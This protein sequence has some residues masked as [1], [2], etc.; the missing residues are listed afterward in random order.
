MQDP[1]QLL[2]VPEALR[3]QLAHA[4]GTTLAA[5]LYAAVE[6]SPGSWCHGNL[7]GW[8]AALASL[9]SPAEASLDG[10]GDTIV[11][12]FG[13]RDEASAKQLASALAELIPWRKGPFEIAGVR[14]DTEWRSDWK[15]ARLQPHIHPLAGRRVLDVGCGSGYHLWRMRA[16][17][18]AVVIGIDPG[19]LFFHQFHAI[20]RYARDS[21][22]HF[23]P[24]TLEALPA[25]LALFDTVFSMGV[26]Y[27]RR[28]HRAHLRQL[29]DCLRPGGELVLETLVAPAAG[30][31]SLPITG[32]YARMR[33]LWEL[34]GPEAL[35]SWLCEAGFTDIR[36]V[37]MGDTMLDEQRSTAWM[38]FDS[39]QAAL[40]P[41]D[42]TRTVEGWPRPCRAIMLAQRDRSGRHDG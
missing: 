22:V 38:P 29:R 32:R 11:V 4:F 21:Q 15:W 12:T 8:Q 25:G 9:P 1:R 42:P 34:P 7:A 36:L 5:Q 40:D 31:T 3:A 18:A 17:G 14:I 20:Q 35:A 28:D 39:L 19:L 26:L 27:H 10:S 24:V 23:L 30:D 13:H 2:P 6:S 16:A 33:N 37:S 41:A